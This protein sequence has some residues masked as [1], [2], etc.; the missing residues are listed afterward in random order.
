MSNQPNHTIMNEKVID[1]E[2]LIEYLTWILENDGELEKFY[3]RE[4]LRLNK[5]DP[6][7]DVL[8]FRDWLEEQTFDTMIKECYFENYTKELYIDTG[9]YDPNSFLHEYLDW[10]SI[11]EELLNSDYDSVFDN[12]EYH[13]FNIFRRE[14]YYHM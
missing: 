5:D 14:F 8:A 4:L 2:E 12:E 1:R 10:E 3:D 11:C 7:P 13:P 6:V 9:E